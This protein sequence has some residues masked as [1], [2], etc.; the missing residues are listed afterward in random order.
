MEINEMLQIQ[1]LFEDLKK[2]TKELAD[3]KIVRPEATSSLE[4]KDLA[5]ALSKAQSE[6]PIAGLNKVNPFFKSNYA[7]F[8]SI[9]SASRPALTKY[10][11]SVTQQ[12]IHNDDGLSTL[13]TTLHHASGQWIL[14]RARITP[15]KNDIQSVS[16]Y[17]TYL[18]RL[19]YSALIGVVTGDEDDDGEVAVATTRETFAKG[20]ALN[21]K[22]NPKDQSTETISPRER[23]EI[24]YE[25]AEFPDLAEKVLDTLGLQSIADMPASKYKASIERIRAIKNSR[26]GVK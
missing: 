6:M 18:K 12:I 2:Q 4:L 23:E 21:T 15:V 5:V 25:L 22:Y 9:V 8:G 16:S 17:V 11:L 24:E 10:G 3:S 13:I 19:C 7:D 26:N 20:T 1:S 14:S